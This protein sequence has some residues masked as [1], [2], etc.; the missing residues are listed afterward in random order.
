MRSNAEGGKYQGIELVS[1][2]VGVQR[3]ALLGNLVLDADG[4]I[5]NYFDPNG[6]NRTL[7][8][9]QIDKGFFFIFHFVGLSAYVITIEDALGNTVVTLETGM[10]A[11][12]TS[13]GEEWIATRAWADLDDFVGAGPNHR[14][15]L[16]PDPGPIAQALRFLREDGVWAEAMDDG[17]VD[18][19]KF[20]TDGTNTATANGGDT[21]RIRSADDSLQITVSNNHGTFGDSVDIQVIEANIDHDLLNNFVA[22]EHVNH[23]S[24]TIGGEEGIQG[25][26]NILASRLLKLAF[27]SLSAANPVLADTAAFLDASDSV[28]KKT[29]FADINA[30]FV[31]DDLVGVE[32]NKHVDHSLVSVVAGVGLSG[33]GPITSSVTLNLDLDDI[34]T[35]TLAADDIILFDNVSGVFK[36]TFLVFNESLDHNVLLN[37]VA[38]EHINHSGVSITA[39]TGLDG[40]GDIT[41]SRTLNLNAASITSLGLADS[42]LQPEAIGLTVQAYDADLTTW[43]SLTPSANFQVLVTQTFAQI[44]ASLDLEAGTDFYSI[45]AANAAFEPINANIV[46]SNVTANLTAGYTSTAEDAGTKSSGT[47]TPDPTVGNIQR[48]VNGGAHTLAPPTND[49]TILIQYTNNASAGA[50]TTSGFT[51]VTG[52]AITTV[53]GDDFFFFITKCNG[54]SHLHVQA[55]Q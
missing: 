35:D 46:K 55:L 31:H 25:G 50:I 49:C 43:A 11:I 21:F 3:L 29:T 7:T 54:F 40:G 6:A 2:R 27:G 15:G 33:G 45:S 23:G 10:S 8:L 48:A 42:A 44:R 13:S 1:I 34:P 22:D 20:I 53:N 4:P 41:T 39:G 38:N 51:K 37:L 12:I 52:S 36:A 5:A 14:R 26:G 32:A 28:H 18:A 9:P 19:F 47:F 30:I 16:V 24:V 17:N